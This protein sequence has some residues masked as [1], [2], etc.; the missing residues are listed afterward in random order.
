[1]SDE[2]SIGLIR[3]GSAW[4]HGHPMGD[5]KLIAEHLAY[6]RALARHGS[7]LQAG[8]VFGL[9]GQPGPDGLIALVLYAVGEPEARKLTEQDPAISSGLVRCDVRPWYPDLLATGV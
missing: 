3:T 9:D 4:E 2:R 5:Q 6:L 1:M 7:V 8:P